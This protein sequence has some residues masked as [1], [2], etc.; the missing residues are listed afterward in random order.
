MPFSSAMAVYFPVGNR[1]CGANRRLLGER[2]VKKRSNTNKKGSKA[3]AMATTSQG[4]D[5]KKDIKAIE[6]RLALLARLWKAWNHVAVDR[7]WPAPGVG[8]W[9]I[10][11]VKALTMQLW[12]QANSLANECAKSEAMV[13]DSISRSLFE[14]VLAIR[15]I[16]NPAV[17]LC[18]RYK[19]DN[20]GK[21]TRG[22]DGR[23]NYHVEKMTGGNKRPRRPANLANEF[24][25]KLFLA[26]IELQDEIY[27]DSKAG[28]PELAASVA[29]IRQSIATA[30]RFWKSQGLT[31]FASSVSAPWR[32]VLRKQGSYAGLNIHALSELLGQDLNLY[33]DTIYH[34]Q[35]RSVHGT[36]TLTHVIGENAAG[37]PTLLF[38]SPP[39]AVRLTLETGL[40]LLMDTVRMMSERFGFTRKGKQEIAK[41]HDEYSVLIEAK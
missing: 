38:D 6:A 20:H 25:A 40:S 22:K 8:P 16:I 41:L 32:R 34:F 11:A 18:I 19:T 23:V 30:K 26:F 15:F 1:M 3:A 37:E 7:R 2:H 21:K 36:A 9:E 14:T 29:Q 13:G 35:S 17:R 28:I 10:V 12:R 24:R 33:Y 27:A 5:P 31:G 4:D 39:A